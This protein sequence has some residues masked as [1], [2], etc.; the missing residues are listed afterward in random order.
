MTARAATRWTVAL[1]LATLALAG[2]A[3]TAAADPLAVEGTITYRVEHKFKTYDAV[4]PASSAEL[5]LEMEPADLE[6]IRFEAEIPLGSFDSGNQ[7]RDQHA[8]ETLELLFFPSARWTVDEVQV[9]RREPATGDLAA[10]ELLVAGPLELHGVIQRLET[11]VLVTRDDAGLRVQARF[12]ISLETYDIPRPGLLG[13]RISDTVTV[14]VDLVI[15]GE[16]P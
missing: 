13:I 5:T 15:T 10:A 1:A 2:L 9:V 16:T 11:T 4:L 7:L 8:A 3:R 14:T 12:P 6:E